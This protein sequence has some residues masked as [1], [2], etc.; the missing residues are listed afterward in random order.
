MGKETGFWNCRA[1]SYLCLVLTGS[2]TLG[3]QA[4]VGGVAFYI[5]LGMGFT[6]L[7]LGIFTLAKVGPSPH[8]DHSLHWAASVLP[9]LSGAG[10]E[11]V[12]G[13]ASL[14][15]CRHTRPA[16]SSPV[17]PATVQPY[18]ARFIVLAS[19]KFLSS[20]VDCQVSQRWRK[21]NMIPVLIPFS[22][23]TSPRSPITNAHNV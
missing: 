10:L 11:S 19:T 16:R 17:V 18:C 4:A 2:L 14:R 3:V 22:S 12:G 21:A 15:L 7:A 20:C 5:S 1:G 13:D 9:I 6:V 23:P 8:K